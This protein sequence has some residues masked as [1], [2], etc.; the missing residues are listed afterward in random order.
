MF[1]HSRENSGNTLFDRIDL[2]IRLCLYDIWSPSV[3][4]WNQERKKNFLRKLAGQTGSECSRK[5][6]LY[7]ITTLCVRSRLRPDS[8]LSMLQRFAS[9]ERGAFLFVTD[10]YSWLFSRRNERRD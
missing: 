9:R 5:T 4:E 8:R 6:F 1:L 3:A 7:R 2:L 10:L